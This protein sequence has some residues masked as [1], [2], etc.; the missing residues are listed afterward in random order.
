MTIPIRLKRDPTAGLAPREELVE[1][2]DVV[3]YPAHKVSDGPP[4]EEPQWEVLEPVEDPG[5]HGGQKTLPDGT[6]LVYLAPRG[7]CPTA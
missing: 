2:V 7:Y 5:T 4:V 6:D 3:G 1:G